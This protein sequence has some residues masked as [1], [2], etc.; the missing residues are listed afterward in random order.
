MSMTD[1]V[2]NQSSHFYLLKTIQL[3]KGLPTQMILFN[4]V[5]KAKAKAN[6]IANTELNW[7]TPK[8]EDKISRGSFDL[9]SNHEDFI[10]TITQLIKED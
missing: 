4:S 7:S 3:V 9:C 5:E 1:L 6:K 8:E 10:Y 2:N